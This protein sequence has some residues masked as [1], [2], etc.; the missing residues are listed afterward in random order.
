MPLD[1]SLTLATIKAIAGVA[2][3]A[4][5]IELFSQVIDLQQSIVEAIAENT[6]LVQ[7]NA[8]LTREVN[9]L[10]EDLDRLKRSRDDR[11]AFV[12]KGD[13]Y[14]RGEGSNE[15]GPFCPK[16]LD[17]DEKPIRMIDR[18]NGYTCC[19]HCNFSISTPGY[20]APPRIARSG[21]RWATDY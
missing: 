2:K 9:R 8:D 1:L 14:W 16:C 10:R 17:A 13:V 12:F 6:S 15:E 18:K 5:K 4:G 7:I 11:A 21:R 19:V 20:V 3:D